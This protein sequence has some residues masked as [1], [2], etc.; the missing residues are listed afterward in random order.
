MRAAALLVLAACGGRSAIVV[1]DPGPHF[2]VAPA[3]ADPEPEPEL[4][5][6]TCSGDKLTPS[7]PDAVLATFERTACYGFC[8]VFEV[9]VLR[10]GRVEYKGHANVLHCDG[11]MQLTPEQLKELEG[12]FVDARFMSLA[13]E[14]TSYDAT[15]GPTI[16]T[17]YMPRP[18]VTKRVEHYTGDLHV[19]EVLEAFEEQFARI[20]D[21]ERFIGSEHDRSRAWHPHN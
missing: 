18:G 13:D 7:D 20:I 15:D 5:F 19:P 9:A 21:I 12:L 6:P 4:V 11:T 16:V 14:Y 1:H 3:P 10:S 17:T 2:A 8:P